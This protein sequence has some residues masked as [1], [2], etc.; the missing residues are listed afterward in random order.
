MAHKSKI[1]KIARDTANLEERIAANVGSQQIDLNQWIFARFSVPEGSNV[2]EL[3]CGTGAQTVYLARQ[4]GRSGRIYALDVSSDAIWKLC[5]NVDKEW[6]DGVIPIE[7]NIDAFPESLREK[8]LTPPCFNA[9]FCAYGL[10]YCSDIRTTL[11][12]IKNWLKP[13][14]ALAVA[15]PFGP[16]NYPLYEILGRRGVKIP[17]VVHNAS[18]RFMLSDVAPWAAEHFERVEFHTMVNKITWDDPEQ[19]LTY[20]K[21]STFYDESKLSA[22]ADLISQH[23]VHNEQFVNEKWVMLLVASSMR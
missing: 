13:E 11:S 8:G 4:A 20:W 3:C 21:N 7:A 14:G 9:V 5:G 19:L 10:Y 1:T 12:D 17:E 18:G 16:N 2:L 22:V 6:A 23:F 15:G